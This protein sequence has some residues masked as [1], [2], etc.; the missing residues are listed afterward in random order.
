METN[1]LKEI[2]FD[3]F[4]EFDDYDDIIE[5]LRSLNSM[6]KLTDDEYDTILSNYD[7]WLKEWEMK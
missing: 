3:L 5:D 4:E 6:G 1:Y 2:L 7:K